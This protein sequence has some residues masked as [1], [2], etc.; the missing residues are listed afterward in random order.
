[1]DFMGDPAGKKRATNPPEYQQHFV[2]VPHHIGSGKLPLGYSSVNS[3]H[4]LLSIT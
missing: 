4:S 1:M 3:G 2:E